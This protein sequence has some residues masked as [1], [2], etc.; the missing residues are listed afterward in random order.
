M[1][2]KSGHRFSDKIMRQNKVPELDSPTQKRPNGFLLGGRSGEYSSANVIRES[3]RITICGA[4][5]RRRNVGI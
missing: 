2:R 1:I 3:G 4:L 5:L